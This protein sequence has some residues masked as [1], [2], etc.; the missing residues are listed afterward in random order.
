M[1]RPLSR[2]VTRR[3][4]DEPGRRAES[5]D[6]LLRRHDPQLR[7]VARIFQPGDTLEF[8]TS[9]RLT[10]LPLVAPHHPAAIREMAGENYRNGQYDVPRYSL[11]VPVPMEAL[12]SSSEFQALEREMRAAAFADKIAWELCE[13]RASKLHASLI[14]DLM[15]ADA[16]HCAD[17]VA[18]LLPRLGPVLFRLGGP[19]IGNKNTGR[20]YFPAY[21]REIDGED[22]FALIQ[23]A[24]GA[25]RTRFYAIGYY[26]LVDQLDPR[27]TADLAALL[28][29]WRSVILAEVQV[30]SLVVHATNDNLALSGRPLIIIDAETASIAAPNVNDRDRA[31][32][33][34]DTR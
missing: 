10:H 2:P 16:E 1:L 11:V 25:A 29:H 14:N 24:A 21:P 27:E 30:A 26:H 32:R 4:T 13:R 22:A 23:D 20:I 28:D 12:T 6:P 34:I 8:D 31:V 3:A 18:R 33:R 9:Y 19:F 7:R 5:D 17:A 15:E